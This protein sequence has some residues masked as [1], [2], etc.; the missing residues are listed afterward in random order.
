MTHFLI[1]SSKFGRKEGKEGGGREK[2]KE[3][4]TWMGAE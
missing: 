3:R 2:R 4:N 1:S